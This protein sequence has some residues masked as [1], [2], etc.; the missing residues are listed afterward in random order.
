M[1]ES[2]KEPPE[3]RIWR[4]YRRDL[5]ESG[6]EST[7]W[8]RRDRHR[9]SHRPDPPPR[10]TPSSGPEYTRFDIPPRKGQKTH[11]KRAGPGPAPGFRQY[12]ELLRERDLQVAGLAFL[13]RHLQRFLA[14]A[15]PRH[16]HHVVARRHRE[17]AVDGVDLLA[18]SH[19]PVIDVNGGVRRLDRQVEP[20]PGLDP[21]VL[22]AAPRIAV[23]VPGL[24]RGRARR[25]RRRLIVTVVTS[26]G[27]RLSWRPD[28]DIPVAVSVRAV[29]SRHRA[30]IPAALP[31]HEVAL[32]RALDL[33]VVGGIGLHARDVRHLIREVDVHPGLRVHFLHQGLV[34]V[35][36]ELDLVVAR[37]Q[38]EVVGIAVEIIGG[39]D[40]SAIE[41]DHGLLG[42]NVGIDRGPSVAGAR[43][44]T[45]PVAVVAAVVAGIT[46]AP[47]PPPTPFATDDHDTVAMAA[48]TAMTSMAAPAAVASAAVPATA[49]TARSSLRGRSKQQRQGE[50]QRINQSLSFHRSRL[51]RE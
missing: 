19:E 17:A 33:G 18:R 38:E 28:L 20:G 30:A 51:P 26:V 5:R 50:R 11:K 15:R 8:S 41:V 34:T 24:S 6:P 49:S 2:S 39:A 36:P 4:R 35:E 32:Y 44:V 29:G 25:R 7:D 16:R 3:A 21:L 31:L 40:R 46:P 9:K 43:A 37:P 42:S 48:V 12:L 1:R 10:A 14:E 13:D 22:I 47:A 27:G 45:V 23:A